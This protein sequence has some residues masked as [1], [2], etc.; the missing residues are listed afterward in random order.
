M[1]VGNSWKAV[2]V[3]MIPS[4]KIYRQTSIHGYFYSKNKL[5]ESSEED[6]PEFIVEDEP[7][8]SEDDETVILNKNLFEEDDENEDDGNIEASDELPVE[9]EKD[10]LDFFNDDGTF[11]MEKFHKWMDIPVAENDPVKIEYSNFTKV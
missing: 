4:Y 5:E 6:E 8:E 10:E 7:T 11:N 2:K 9:L 3:M 1:N